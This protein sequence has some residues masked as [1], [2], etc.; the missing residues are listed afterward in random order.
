MEKNEYEWNKRLLSSIQIKSKRIFKWKDIRF[1]RNK[2]RNYDLIYGKLF[3]KHRNRIEWKEK[4]SLS[5]LYVITLYKCLPTYSMFIISCHKTQPLLRIFIHKS[6]TG[7]LIGYRVSFWPL[8]STSNE[9][10]NF[11]IF[12]KKQKCD[13]DQLW[14]L[15]IN[16]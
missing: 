15:A 8:Y 5:S 3:I 4:L 9:Q 16:P 2:K 6:T 14:F 10:N 7:T 1:C 12:R 13:N 11:N